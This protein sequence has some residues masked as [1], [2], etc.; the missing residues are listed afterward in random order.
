MADYIVSARKYR[1]KSFDEV[2]GQSH[3]TTTLSNA[4]KNN[5]LAHAMLF[6][7][8]RGIGKTTCARILAKTINDFDDSVLE[9]SGMAMNIFE[10][11]A[12]SN[13]HVDDMKSLMDQVRYPPQGGKYKIYIIDEVHMLSKS[14]FNAFLKTL[15]EPPSYVIFILATTEK[16]KVLPTI[17]SRCQIYDFNRINVPEI[18]GHLVNI[19]KKENVESEKDALHLIAQKSEGSLRDA[20]SLFDQLVAFSG[21]NKITYEQVLSNLHILDYDYFLKLTSILESEDHESAV[22]LF[23]EILGKGFDGLQLILGFLEHL[24]NLLMLKATS[25]SRLVL[26]PPSALKQ[27][28]EQSLLVDSS[29][30]LSWISI[31]QGCEQ[32]YKLSQNQ[33]ILVELTLVKMA[34]LKQVLGVEIPENIELKKKAHKEGRGNGEDSLG[35]KNSGY[36]QAVKKIE[37]EAREES[38][39]PIPEETGREPKEK[40]EVPGPEIPENDQKEDNGREFSAD[41]GEKVPK[42]KKQDLESDLQKEGPRKISVKSGV[43]TSILIDE[44]GLEDEDNDEPDLIKLMKEIPEDQ[45]FDEEALKTAW[46]KYLEKNLKEFLPALQRILERKPKLVDG[47]V[48]FEIGNPVEENHLNRVKAD[49]NFHL[50]K[51]LRNKSVELIISQKPDDEE[52]KPYTSLEKFSAMAK[53]NPSLLELKEKL[54][55]EIEF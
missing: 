21:N 18:E 36:S 3:I 34:Y 53:V 14:A 43:H 16:N 5:Q 38:I 32:Q 44:E 15:E 23:D 39:L 35:P 8:P 40:N 31:L 41:V 9:G 22:L 1:P 46:E 48:L 13:N 49:L 27:Y 47:K 12:A 29:L 42:W 19:S 30:L 17:L 33:K 52:K 11:D 6:T 26:V 24:R 54:G 51:T 20:L 25:T 55:L 45:D 10:L 50:K 4:I 7:G 37:K 28:E 2:V